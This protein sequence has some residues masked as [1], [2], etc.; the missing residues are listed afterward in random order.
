M[1]AFVAWA[2]IEV[3]EHEAVTSEVEVDE[4]AA[5]LDQSVGVIEGEIGLAYT[6][7]RVVNAGG[8]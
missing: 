4:E 7:S 5:A 3:P 8:I 1:Q 2:S 6:R